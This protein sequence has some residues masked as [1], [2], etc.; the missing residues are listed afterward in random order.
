MRSMGSVEPLHKNSRIIGDTETDHPPPTTQIAS[1]TAAISSACAV[2]AESL[3]RDK[4][5]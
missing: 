5:S 2:S 3:R 1:S 4:R